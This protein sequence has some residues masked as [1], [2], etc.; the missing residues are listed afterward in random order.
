MKQLIITLLLLISANVSAQYSEATDA[1]SKELI[2][3]ITKSSEEMKS[4]QCDFLQVK[5]LSFMDDKVTS[6]GR[7]FFKQP[8]SIRWEY[9]KP[10]KYV[11]TTDG[12]NISMTSGDKTNKVPVRQS[13]LFDKISRVMVGG[14]S[15]AGL[16][17]SSDFSIKILIGQ[18]DSKIV[19]TPTEK[20]V[21]DLFSVI[22]LTISKP[23]ARIVAVEMTEKT[24]D[25]TTITLKN[26]KYN[27]DISDTL[28]SNP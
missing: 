3:A 10:Y 7:M 1:Q 27:E 17:D 4:M 15:G 22:H 28:F 9:S 24:G 13:K 5:E 12:K 2:A 21:K 18:K 6:E 8:K 23:E 26:V 11:F 16:M 20:E 25:K 14:V 19:L